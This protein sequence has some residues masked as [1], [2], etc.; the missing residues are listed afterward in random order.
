VST[1]CGLFP[2]AAGVMLAIVS[3][4]QL[5][6]EGAFVALGKK[7]GELCANS[8]SQHPVCIH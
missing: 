1:T 2:T 8:Q 4:S 7:E 6:G 3:I 5:S